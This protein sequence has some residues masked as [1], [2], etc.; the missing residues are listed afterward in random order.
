MA[1]STK[2]YRLQVRVIAVSNFSK[3][4]IIRHFDVPASRIHVVWSGIKARPR[5]LN[6]ITNHLVLYVGSLFTRRNLPTLIK[7][8]KKV[9]SEI[10][11]AELVIVGENRTYPLQDLRAIIGQEGLQEKVK[12]VDY[13]S[14]NELSD[15]YQRASV[16]V[17]LS[18]YEGFGFTPLEALSARVPI[19]VADT[20]VA[21]EVYGNTA[22][23]VD[24]TD[25]PGT[26]KAIVSLVN[27]EELRTKQQI[28]TETHL[29]R[30]SWE[31]SARETLKIL[32]AAAKMAPM[33]DVV[34]I[35]VNFNTRAHLEACLQSIHAS[36]SSV[37]YEIIVVDNASTDGSVEAVRFKLAIGSYNR[38]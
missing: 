20:P 15:F 30:F 17:F 6:P 23:F 13:V 22:S 16:F 9:T 32:E 35:I 31:R 26:A 33:I 37:R 28:C 21:R 24:V 18:E 27:D 11:D 8:F 34:I 3:D 10:Q 4:E 7:V 19:V 14:E 5:A 36:N 25:L 38:N 12:L 29:T 2:P 1:G